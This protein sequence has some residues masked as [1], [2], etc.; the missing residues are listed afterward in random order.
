MRATDPRDRSTRHPVFATCH[1]RAV[2]TVVLLAMTGAA[3]PA[4]GQVRTTGQ[5]VGTVKDPTGAVVPNAA[6]EVTDAATG[7]VQTSKSSSEGGFVFPALQPGRYR[8]LATATGFEPAV[9]DG[10]VV[11]TG[12]SSNVEVQV[13]V[14]A[15]QEQVRVVGQSPVVETTSSTISTTVGNREIANLPLS[16]RDVL[17]FALLTPGT[18]SSSTQRFSTFNGLPK[19]RLRLNEWGGN[20]VGPLRKGKLF[21]FANFE[22]PIQPSDVTFTRTLLN[23]DAQRGMFRYSATDGSVRAVNL[24]DIARSN[25]FP[26]AI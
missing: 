8:I 13:A 1:H 26:S 24:L 12:R 2:I 22:Q 16:G 14:A 3:A 20:I 21:Y 17:G 11:E 18:A 10:I 7:N 4:R 5:I 15:L 6:V 9:V 19:T 23:Q 25:G